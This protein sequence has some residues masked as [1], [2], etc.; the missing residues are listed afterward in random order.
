MDKE[1]FTVGNTGAHSQSAL[2][3]EQGRQGGDGDCGEQLFLSS[4]FYHVIGNRALVNPVG[5]YHQSSD[6]F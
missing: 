2:S 3:G 4:R 6:L 1:A 5:R